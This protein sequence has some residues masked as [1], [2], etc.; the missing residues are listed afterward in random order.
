MKDNEL[1]AV[2]VM[3]ITPGLPHQESLSPSFPLSFLPSLS[4]NLAAQIFTEHLPSPGHPAR[5]WEHSGN[6]AKQESHP[7]GINRQVLAGRCAT[8]H[9]RA[10]VDRGGAGSMEQGTSQSLSCSEGTSKQI[11]EERNATARQTEEWEKVKIKYSGM[12]QKKV[13]VKKFQRPGGT[14]HI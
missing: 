12:G 3:N 8:C 2:M 6:C 1:E 5:T 14:R 4:M 9:D 13:H 11:L 10:G 7:R